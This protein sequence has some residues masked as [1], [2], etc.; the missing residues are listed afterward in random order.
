MVDTEKLANFFKM[1][2]DETRLKIIEE[3]VIK[4][5]SVNE[6]KDKLNMTQTNVSYQ[7]RI[8]RDSHIVKYRKVQQ[9]VFYSIDDEH[10]S[11]LINVARLHLEEVKD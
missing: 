2:S 3:L 11:Y 4:E 6:L 8:L 5:Y 9:N 7:L 1:F 10:I